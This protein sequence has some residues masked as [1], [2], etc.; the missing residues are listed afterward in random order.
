VNLLMDLLKDEK[1]DSDE[2]NIGNEKLEGL[3]FQ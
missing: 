2:E 3:T 1:K